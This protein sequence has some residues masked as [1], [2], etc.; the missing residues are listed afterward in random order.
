[1]QS[2]LCDRLINFDATHAYES[3]DIEGLLGQIV[4]VAEPTAVVIKNAHYLT[5]VA[6]GLLHNYLASKP[7]NV[8]FVMSGDRTRIFPPLLDYVA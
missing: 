4:D 3:S 5:A 7:D 2:L 6:C 1:M 8:A